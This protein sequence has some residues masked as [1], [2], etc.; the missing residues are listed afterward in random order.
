[1]VHPPSQLGSGHRRRGL[2][3]SLQDIGTAP[4]RWTTVEPEFWLVIWMGFETSTESPNFGNVCHDTEQTSTGNNLVIRV[5]LKIRESAFEI[6]KKSGV[7]P[8]LSYCA[9]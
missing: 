8:V 5:E 7:T 9:L 6:R 3:H 2:R 4:S 1:M